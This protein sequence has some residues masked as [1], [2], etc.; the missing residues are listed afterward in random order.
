MLAL[1]AV[2][3]IAIGMF[4][5]RIVDRRRLRVALAS[6]GAASVDAMPADSSPVIATDTPRHDSGHE[7]GLFEGDVILPPYE[8]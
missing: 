1:Y 5:L 3:A 8:R 2:S 6:S 7:A 4:L